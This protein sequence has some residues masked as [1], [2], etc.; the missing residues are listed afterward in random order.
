MKI[1]TVQPDL[2][3]TASYE[4]S[5]THFEVDS[6]DHLYIYNGED[7]VAIYARAKWAHVRDAEQ[8]DG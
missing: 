7:V 1:I 8:S 4:H 3:Y 2:T 6:H 5:G